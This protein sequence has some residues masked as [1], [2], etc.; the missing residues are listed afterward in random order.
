MVYRDYL[1]HKSAREYQ[2][3]KMAK[4]MGF[5]L[6]EHTTTLN[7]EEGQLSDEVDRMPLN[8]L[9]VLL[10]QCFLNRLNV[11]LELDNAGF[12]ETKLGI[13][14]HVDQYQIGLKTEQDYIFITLGQILTLTISE[15]D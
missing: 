1:P 10:N 14:D 2:D 13:V 7:T 12:V 5:F 8:Q 11:T 3:R 4:W 6:S 9:I 15:E